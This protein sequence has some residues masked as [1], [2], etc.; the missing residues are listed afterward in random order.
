MVKILK[1][2]LS[3]FLVLILASCSS[4]GGDDPGNGGGNPM[5]SAPTQVSQIIFPSANLLCTDNTITFQWNASTDADNDPIRY[6]VIIALDR[7]LNNIVEERTVSSNSFTITLQQATAYYW[8]VTALD[9][10]GDEA[11]PSQTFAFFTSGPGVTNY[12]PFTAELVAPADT[13]SVS[14]GTVNLSWIGADTDAGDT[15]TYDLYFGDVM[16]PP[17]SQSG[18]TAENEDVT[19]TAGNTYYWRVDTIDDSNVKTIGQ[20]WSFTAN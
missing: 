15:L 6:R 14:A 8:N 3:L 4:G 11:Q 13:G 7:D 9:D 20:I 16:D 17:L 10:M 12:A 5:N 19:T 18:L 2:Y 1:Q